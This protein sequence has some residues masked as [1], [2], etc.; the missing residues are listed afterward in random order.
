MPRYIFVPDRD[1]FEVNSAADEGLDVG[2]SDVVK[3]L[4]SRPAGVNVES[5]ES[6]LS[7]IVVSEVTVAV[8]PVSRLAFID[9]ILPP[10]SAQKREQLLNFAIEDKLTIDPATVHA[11]VLGPS[12]IGANHYVVAAIDRHW[13]AAALQWL[14]RHDISVQLAVPETALQWVGG[15]E[16]LVHLHP[17]AGYAVRADG[18]AYGIDQ[19]DADLSVPPFALTLALNEAAAAADSRALPTRINIVAAAEVAARI[20]R[21]QWQLALGEQSAVGIALDVKADDGLRTSVV[22]LNQL[23]RSNLLVGPFKP[24]SGASSWQTTLRPAMLVAAAIL[25]LHFVFIGFDAWRLSQQRAALDAQTRTLFQ[26]SF[27]EATTIVDP[28]LQMSR[29]LAQVKRERGVSGEPLLEQLALAASLTTDV[30][31]EIRSLDYVDGKLTITLTRNAAPTLQSSLRTS[32]RARVTT[33]VEAT[34]LT[35]DRQTP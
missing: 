17:R 32:A 7:A 19:Q 3:W 12:N 8:I 18:L 16:W 9:A 20:D 23:A 24:V 22:P 29:N 15:G 4:L 27:P 2:A 30:A 34:S 25:A 13:L 10:V 6:R 28:V 33:S 35:L 14:A 1:Q 21:Q 5:G 31:A 26:Q 11:V